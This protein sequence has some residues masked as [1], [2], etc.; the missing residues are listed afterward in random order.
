M[1]NVCKKKR[2]VFMRKGN[3]RFETYV[4]WVGRE[5]K[6]VFQW[7]YLLNRGTVD[8]YFISDYQ[9]DFQE[10][11]ACTLKEFNSCKHWSGE[12]IAMVLHG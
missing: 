8:S 2:R 4:K 3:K 7:D 5:L 12:F 6:M 11:R 9:I 1:K 10:T